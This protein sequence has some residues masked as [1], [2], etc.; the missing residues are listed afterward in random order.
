MPN[1]RLPA[2]TRSADGKWLHCP[3]CTRG[4]WGAFR[5]TDFIVAKFT[6]HVTRKHGDAALPHADAP[7]TSI[8]AAA[9]AAAALDAAVKARVAVAPVAPAAKPK[10]AP[11]RARVAKI[12]A[13]AAA[14]GDGAV[15]IIREDGPRTAD[16]LG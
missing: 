6:A 12:A 2:L 14:R 10:R 7:V 4:Y 15:R 3:D 5:P 8:G 16:L 13:K 11:A 1:T 9:D